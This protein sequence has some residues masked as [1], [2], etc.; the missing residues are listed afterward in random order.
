[1]CLRGEM[2]H[3]FSCQINLCTVRKR[4]VCQRYALKRGKCDTLFHVNFSSKSERL[5][6]QSFNE[7]DVI[8][9]KDQSKKCLWTVN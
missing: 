1:M 2:W 8:E 3:T 9:M 5:V 4:E 6:N 7:D